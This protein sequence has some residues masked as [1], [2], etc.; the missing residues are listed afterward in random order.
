ME[1]SIE[2]KQK[3][4]DALKEQRATSG[5][6][7]ANLARRYGVNTSVFS[8]IINGETEKIMDAAKWLYIGRLL[9]VSATNRK[10]NAVKTDVF[11]E[12]EGQVLFCKEYSKSRI[13]VDDCEIGK[14][15]AAKY[16][17]QTLPNCF[18]IDASQCKTKSL[19]IRTL[20]QVLGVDARGT[21]ANVKE[22][23]KYYLNALP[24]PVVILDEF[25]DVENTAF[26]ELKELWNATEYSCGWYMMGAEGL[27]DK[28]SRCIGRKKV[29]FVEIYSRFSSRIGSITP[30]DMNAKKTFYRKLLTEV[31][32]ANT[33]NSSIVATI[34][35]KCLVQSDNK[36]GGLRRAESLLILNSIQ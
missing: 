20:A 14:S 28:I 34:V 3:V 5:L 31:I 12:I 8:R 32:T 27:A 4:I 18:Y 7:D 13:F 16:L 9:G 21:L 2:Y 19:F 11:K 17:A 23:I 6:K 22:Q 24:K 10:W 33:T 30:L 1:I 26:L 29:G 36:F 15:F 25:G 35:N